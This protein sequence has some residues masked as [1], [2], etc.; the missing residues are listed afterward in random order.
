MIRLTDIIVGGESDAGPFE[1]RL[2]FIEGLQVVSAHNAFGKSLA[3]KAVAWCLG[4]EAIF[5]RPMNDSSFFPR[6]LRQEIELDTTEKHCVRASVCTIGLSREDGAKIRL[7]RDVLG[8]PEHVRVEEISAKGGEPR[9][10]TLNA[11]IE[12]MQD[13]HGGLQ[14]FLFEWLG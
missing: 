13:E 10:S 1:G 6:A 3:V 12:T 5:G 4:A 7:S 8:T 2:E 9:R 11:R 14:R